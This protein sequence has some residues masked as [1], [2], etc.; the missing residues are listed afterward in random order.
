MSLRP[1]EVVDAFELGDVALRP[2]R[3]LA[4]GEQQ[5]I[6]AATAVATGPKVLLADE[7]TCQLD[8]SG[9]DTVVAALSRAHALNGS[10]VVVVTHDP[11][12][13]SALPRTVEIANGVI[14]AE[15]RGG[16]RYAVVSGDGAVQ[17]PVDIL[18]VHPPGTLLQVNL[19]GG[20]VELRP[21]DLAG[22]DA[23]EEDDRS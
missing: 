14:G 18:A 3:E 17:L 9:R 11:E 20:A 8:R 15:G 5:R 22:K 1:S 10:T 6:A 12:V 7:P 13:A 4:A 16:Q 23:H 2:V 19:K 21:Q